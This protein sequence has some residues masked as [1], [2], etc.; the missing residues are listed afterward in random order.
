MTVVITCEHCD[1]FPEG[2][3]LF[4]C[5]YRGVYVRNDKIQCYVPHPYREIGTIKCDYFD[6]KKEKGLKSYDDNRT[7]CSG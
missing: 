4:F 3:S 6:Y 5:P 1:H 2:M 7:R